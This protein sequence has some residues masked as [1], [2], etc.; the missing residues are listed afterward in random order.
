MAARLAGFHAELSAGHYQLRH[1]LSRRSVL[2][3]GPVQ[4]RLVTG[5][6]HMQNL[7]WKQPGVWMADLLLLVE[8]RADWFCFPH[9]KIMNP[10]LLGLKSPAIEVSTYRP[11]WIPRCRTAVSTWLRKWRTGNHH[12]SWANQQTKRPCSIAMQ[13]ITRGLSLKTLR[14]WRTW[15]HLISRH[16]WVN[17][18]G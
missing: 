6:L 7:V 1:H 2:F 17:V 5:H 9:F 13:Q 16:P 4:C 18:V 11:V 14:T 12:Y 3:R 15:G 10:V 8:Y